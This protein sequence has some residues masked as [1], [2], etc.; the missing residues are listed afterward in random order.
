MESVLVTGGAGWLGSAITR[1][2]AK[3]GE[4]VIAVDIGR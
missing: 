3:R 2:L 1:R 4:Q